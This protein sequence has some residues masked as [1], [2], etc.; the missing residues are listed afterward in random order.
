MSCSRQTPGRLMG[1]SVP[2]RQRVGRGWSVGIGVKPRLPW[3]PEPRGRQSV[4]SDRWPTHH[5]WAHRK[6]AHTT[7]LRV[8]VLRAPQ[9]VQK[10]S[11]FVG[12]PVPKGS[13]ALHDLVPHQRIAVGSEGVARIFRMG[14]LPG[15]PVADAHTPQRL[16]SRPEANTGRVRNGIHITDQYH[17][18]VLLAGAFFHEPRSCHGLQLA[19]ML[20]VQPPVGKMVDE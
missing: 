19:L 10:C 2:R 17:L 11:R 9:D 7:L 14:A 15:I 20:K 16:T 18:L 6:P 1:W 4:R 12:R 8:R 3:L 5:E 13:S